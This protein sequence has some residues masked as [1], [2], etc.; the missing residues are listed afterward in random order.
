MTQVVLLSLAD[1][2]RY[3][4]ELA[5]RKVADDPVLQKLELARQTTWLT[6]LVGAFLFFHLTEKLGEA[7]HMLV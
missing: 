6:L 1:L 2:R 4:A 3:N 7:L 5:T